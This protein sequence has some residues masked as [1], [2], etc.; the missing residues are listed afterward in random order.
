M[1]VK[2]EKIKISKEDYKKMIKHCRRKL[3]KKYFENET[4]EQ[5]AFGVVIGKK[6]NKDEIEIT[7]VEQLNINYRFDKC[8]SEKMNELIKTYAIPGKTNIEERAW[9]SDPVELSKILSSMEYDEMCIGTYHMHHNASWRG[10]YPRELPTEL[11]KV[12]SKKSGLI[13]F[14]V[15]ISENVIY[16]KIR[17]FYEAEVENELNIVVG[18]E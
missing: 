16:D 10:E 14:I 7:R 1:V 4:K 11:D 18:S 6:N 13:T 15:Y 3:E 12:L 2:N 17:A 5:Q 9:V 8:M